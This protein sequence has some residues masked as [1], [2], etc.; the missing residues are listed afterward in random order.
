MTE[1]QRIRAMREMWAARCGYN[2]EG[3]SLGGRCPRWI[4]R[5]RFYGPNAGRKGWADA[6]HR[7]DRRVV[8]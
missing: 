1:E 5:R 4:G 6:E 2:V 3:Y 7:A 8:P